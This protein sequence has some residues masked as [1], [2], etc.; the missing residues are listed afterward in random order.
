MYLLWFESERLSQAQVLSSWSSTVG[1]RLR[2]V[3]FKEVQPSWQKWVTSGSLKVKTDAALGLVDSAAI[4]GAAAAP[5]S[6]FLLHHTETSVKW[7]AKRNVSFFSSKLFLL[8]WQ[9]KWHLLNTYCIQYKRLGRWESC[10]GQ[11]QCGQMASSLLNERECAY[12]RTKRHVS[13]IKNALEM[14]CVQREKEALA[15]KSRWLELNAEGMPT[16]E[17]SLPSSYSIT[18]TVHWCLA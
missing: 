15:V 16:A 5:M 4:G 1:T 10:P 6:L 9:E 2:V 14:K 12:G 11:D 7:W 13:Q 18:H 3:R 17:G 8:R